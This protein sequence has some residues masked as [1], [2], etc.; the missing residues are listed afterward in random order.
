M[1]TFNRLE[2]LRRT[3]PTLANQDFPAE[4]YEIVVVDDGC[5]DGTAEFLE[6]E[7][8]TARLRVIRQS[9]QG[10]AAARNAGLRT[11]RGETVIFVDDDMI[12]DPA[13]VRSH[14]LA[15]DA[16]PLNVSIGAIFLARDCR[17]T[18]A[19][20]CFEREIGA[21]HL[22]FM[23]NPGIPV[24]PD[25]WVF[26]NTA[27]RRAE[28]LELGGFDDSLRKREDAELGLRL[29][30]AGFKLSYSPLAIAQQLYVK[31]PRDLLGDAV[32]F[33]IADRA[34]MEKYPEWRSKSGFDW[35]G[36]RP[37]WCRAVRAT[38]AAIP[39]LPDA[40]LSACWWAG[41]VL[42]AITPVRR[43]GARALQWH[44][45]LVWYRAV[46]RAERSS[47][48]QCGLQLRPSDGRNNPV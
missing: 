13:L 11:A 2:I 42:Q 21:F 29:S 22:R 3:L 41:R 10:P 27:V 35:G 6:S 37:A 46:C 5:S 20:D 18:V 31:S 38:A 30:A 48:P 9:N 23:S 14:V 33:G 36:S 1:P 7:R 4:D 19:S 34:L 40:I 12:C 25:C 16:D 17:C 45:H 8:D 28:L 32:V 24:P 44:R 26:S 39:V 47:A 15:C 43:L